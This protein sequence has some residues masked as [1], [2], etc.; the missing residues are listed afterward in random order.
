MMQRYRTLSWSKEPA[1][2]CRGLALVLVLWVLLMLTLMATSFVSTVRVEMALD[3]QFADA[4]RARAIGRAGIH[5]VLAG[6]LADNG[7]TRW[8]AAG[9]IYPWFFDGHNVNLILEDEAGKV[10]LNRATPELL[11]AVLGLV[12]MTQG[13]FSLDEVL[14]D[15]KDPD[16]NP[17]PMGA[18]DA[19]YAQAGLAYGARDDMLDSVE[20]LGLMLGVNTRALMSIS[21]WLTVYS[22]QTGINPKHAD[23]EL[24]RLLPGMTDATLQNYLIQRQ[25]PGQA[26]LAMPQGVE[27]R[28]FVNSAGPY[29]VRALID[30]EGRLAEY[31][32]VVRIQRRGRQRYEV[33]EKRFFWVNG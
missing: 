3:G 20:E 30:M 1:R 28:F 5:L 27:P 4:V 32:V 21:R 31:Q 26:A 23:P 7:A 13:H 14:Q 29:R 24:L 10:D 15:W 22:R 2:R 25:E 8:Q 9:Q 33:L 19:H 17:L 16:Q 11:K 18:E 12:P 6:L